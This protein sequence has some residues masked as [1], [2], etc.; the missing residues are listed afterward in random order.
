MVEL[1]GDEGNALLE[2]SCAGTLKLILYHVQSSRGAVTS[3]Y[4]VVEQ[5]GCGG[6]GSNTRDEDTVADS[7]QGPPY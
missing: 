1:R 2:R 6:S 5:E 3:S 7:S 4:S